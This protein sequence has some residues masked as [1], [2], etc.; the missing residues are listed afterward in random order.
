LQDRGRLAIQQIGKFIFGGQA[1][2]GGAGN[3]DPAG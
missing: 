1:F 2:P 3:H